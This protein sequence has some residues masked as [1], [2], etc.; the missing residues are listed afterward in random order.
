M[1]EQRI[2]KLRTFLE[3]HLRDNETRRSYLGEQADLYTRPDE[4][5]GLARRFAQGA[6]NG[7]L[8]D[9]L[10]QRLDGLEQPV[11]STEPLSDGAKAFL[12]EGDVKSLAGRVANLEDID[13]G[14]RIDADRISTAPTADADLRNPT[15]ADPDAGARAPIATR[16][17]DGMEA[18]ADIL[19]DDGDAG[20][21]SSV[22]EG[23]FGEISEGDRNILAGNSRFK[24]NINLDDNGIRLLIAAR[25]DLLEFPAFIHATQRMAARDWEAQK[26]RYEEIQEK[27]ARG[28]TLTE[29]E[30]RIATAQNNFQQWA[31][32]KMATPEGLAEIQKTFKQTSP[33]LPHEGDPL[34]AGFVAFRSDYGSFTDRLGGNA[35]IVM[36]DQKGTEYFHYGN[37]TQLKL[38][39]GEKFEPRHAM[40]VVADLIQERAEIKED[41]RVR[42]FNITLKSWGI[43]SDKEALGHEI[44]ATLTQAQR[45]DCMEAITIKTKQGRFGSLQTHDQIDEESIPAS[46][47]AQYPEASKLIKLYNQRKDGGLEAEVETPDPAA[48]TVSEPAALAAGGAIHVGR[49]PAA[50][51]SLTH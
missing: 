41:G 8:S 31:A 36:I 29:E 19:D 27:I 5:R 20:P 45:T 51:P 4:I 47:R 46:V 38:K 2:E 14:A 13:T 25:P 44:M 40:N 23:L 18:E 22:F 37:K 48:R 9:E 6:V 24:K 34:G 12:N 3:H 43:F 10:L 30:Q 49:R 17:A 16:P 1:T 26:T 39:K 50:P 21:R 32:N 7:G 11:L 15:L 42:D 28:E 33:L 35:A